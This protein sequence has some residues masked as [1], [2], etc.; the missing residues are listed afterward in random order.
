MH[1]SLVN[2]LHSLWSLASLFSFQRW[3]TLGPSI[4]YLSCINCVQSQLSALLL[5]LLFNGACS[6]IG[7]QFMNN[8]FRLQNVVLGHWPVR[9]WDLSIWTIIFFNQRVKWIQDPLFG[10]CFSTN[11]RLCCYICLWVHQWWDWHMAF[12]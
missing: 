5:F 7:F 4:A 2:L 10:T 3:D 8:S 11:L 12:R 1:S 6:S 9:P